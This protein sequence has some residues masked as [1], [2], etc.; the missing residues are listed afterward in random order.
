M[1]RL[2]L[3]G[4]TIA[5]ALI[6]STLA[7]GCSRDHATARIDGTAQASPSPAT[8]VKLVDV[9]GSLSSWNRGRSSIDVDVKSGGVRFV[10]TVGAAPGWG[11]SVAKFHYW[12]YPRTNGQK[13]PSA[14]PL[15]ATVTSHSDWKT[16]DLRSTTPLPPG[17]YNLLY[18]G[19][20]WY[21]MTVYL[22]VQG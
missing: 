18:N 9:G 7:L 22:S 2:I 6:V 14:V 3:S 1:P 10:V 16:Y 5:L 4:T 12:L 20:G 21:Q 8:W 13:P 11:A 17:T 19:A 15:H